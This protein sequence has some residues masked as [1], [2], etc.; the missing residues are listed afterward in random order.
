[1]PLQN[2]ALENIFIEYW[3]LWYLPSLLLAGLMICVLHM[4]ST[5]GLVC[6]G[7]KVLKRQFIVNELPCVKFVDDHGSSAVD[8]EKEPAFHA[9]LL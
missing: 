3:C 7:P 1:V 5:N 6:H 4:P 2:G 8:G 9:W